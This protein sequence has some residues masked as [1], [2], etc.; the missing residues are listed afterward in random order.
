MLQLTSYRGA[1]TVEFLVDE[2]RNFYFLEV[3][4]RLQVEHPITELRHGIDLVA[5]QLRVAEGHSLPQLV[6]MG[7]LP[8][9]CLGV[10]LRLPPHIVTRVTG[11]PAHN[12]RDWPCH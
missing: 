9:Y 11:T 1:G 12:S 2:Q 5:L 7:Q 3:N 10:W 4:T 8:Q 6:E